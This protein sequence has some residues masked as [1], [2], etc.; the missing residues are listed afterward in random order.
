MEDVGEDAPR[1]CAQRSGIR[2]ER[3]DE[4]AEVSR[5]LGVGAKIV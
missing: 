4:I 1:L 5:C 2:A 3:R